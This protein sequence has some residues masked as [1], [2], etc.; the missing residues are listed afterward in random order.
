MAEHPI[1]TLFFTECDSGKATERSLAVLYA[2]I[3]AGGEHVSDGEWT[4]INQAA[5]R[6]LGSTSHRI[7]S[8]LKKLAWDM[9]DAAAVRQKAMAPPRET[10]LPPLTVQ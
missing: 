6:A 10:H 2:L 3:I 1:L 8:D 5:M 4:R 9:Q 7:L